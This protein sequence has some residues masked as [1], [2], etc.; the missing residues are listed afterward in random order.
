MTATDG[1]AATRDLLAKLSEGLATYQAGDDRNYPFGWH[2]DTATSPFSWH[3]WGS[4]Q[5]F[6]LVARDS[7]SPGL[8]GSS[9][10]SA[11]PI[12]SMRGC[13]L[14][15][16]S[17]SGVCFPQEFPQIAYGVNSL[18]QGLVALHQATGDETYGKLAGLTAGW[19][20]GNNAA[21]FAMYDPATGRATMAFTVQAAS[22]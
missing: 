15:K 5:V 19:F 4:T 22:V 21:G 1:H 2:P 13:W 3:A 18:V 17:A 20:Y 14:E 6:A 7:S 12:A 11:R 9:R 16:W 10:R 8:N